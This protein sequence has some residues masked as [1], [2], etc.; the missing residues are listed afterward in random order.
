MSTSRLEDISESGFRTV[1]SDPGDPD[2]EKVARVVV[3]SGKVF[4]DLLDAR[5]K[6]E[7]DNIALVRIEQLYPFPT[8]RFVEELKRYPNADDI[9]WCQEEPKN[10]G[11]WLYIR[12]TLRGNMHSK[13][14]LSFAGRPAAASPAV[15]YYKKHMQ[16][17]QAL[18]DAALGQK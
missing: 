14:H 1:I 10:Q 18:V 7:I 6:R 2:A 11:A 8:D 15:G 9:V 13:Q 5:H 16:Q 3:C 4:F 17:L 12:S